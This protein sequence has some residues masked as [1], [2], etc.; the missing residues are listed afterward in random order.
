MTARREMFDALAKTDAI[1]DAAWQR[2]QYLHRVRWAMRSIASEF[3]PV[4]VEA[5]RLYVL[6][7]RP[8]GETAEQLGVSRDSIYQA[9]SRGLKRL[10]EKVALLESDVGT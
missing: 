1:H 2:E 9:K 7:N 4:T 6:A 8:V 5:F 3:E 10:R